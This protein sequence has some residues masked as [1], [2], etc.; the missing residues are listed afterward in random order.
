M[1]FSASLAISGAAVASAAVFPR[2]A[3]VDYC[4]VVVKTIGLSHIELSQFP[5]AMSWTIEEAA[6]CVEKSEYDPA[7]YWPK[8]NT[9]DGDDGSDD[10]GPIEP[11]S[12][13]ASS[14]AAGIPYPTGHAN[15][16]L[17]LHYS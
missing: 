10:S 1:K 6:A 11:S 16:S 4:P 5:P 9:T 15:L 2:E 12:Y 8:L 17:S 7:Q 3:S 13:A 14:Y